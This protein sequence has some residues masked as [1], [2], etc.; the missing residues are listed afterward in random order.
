MCI[1]DSLNSVRSLIELDV[2]NSLI[3]DT[4]GSAIALVSGNGNNFNQVALLGPLADNGGPTQTHSLLPGSL[5]INTGSN[6]LA[7][8]AGLTADQR[9]EGRIQFGT[10]DIGA[11]ESNFNERNLVVTTNLDVED[12][13]DG[14]TSLREAIIISNEGSE[15]ST[16]T[17]DSSVFGVPTTIE[18][19]SC[20]LYTSPSP[21]D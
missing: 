18:I 4:T 10:V 20:L 12:P 19:S 13:N 14:L 17:F 3:G 8:A 21:R 16:I 5:A 1:R 7:D 15:T 2:E 9:G 6:E 11:F